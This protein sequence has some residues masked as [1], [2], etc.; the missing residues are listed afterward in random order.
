MSRTEL[1]ILISVLAIVR[2]SLAYD[3]YAQSV[4]AGEEDPCADAKCT[5]G[6]YCKDGKCH[7]YDTCPTDWLV[8]QNKI[9]VDGY[10][11]SHTC[12]LYRNIC[13]CR[14][15]DQRCGDERYFGGHHAD[16]NSIIR[17]FAE[18]Q[19]LTH[20]CNWA[21]HQRFFR[22]QLIVWLQQ[23]LGS[24]N[25]GTDPRNVLLRPRAQHDW[26]A[27]DNLLSK[28]IGLRGENAGP[29]L[30]FV[31]CEL[32]VDK[33]GIIEERELAMLTQVALPTL[34][35]LEIFLG[36]CISGRTISRDAWFNCFEIDTREAMSCSNFV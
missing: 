15:G 19:E 17:Y 18:C 16:Q 12:D 7:C 2:L 30:S 31:F 33:S 35:C 24:T 27:L 14:E 23:L 36:N 13:Y 9:C 29:I 1:L 25:H 5:V 20:K 28:R 11:Y 34:A 22:Y 32:D 26:L 6:E 21:V 4:N 10:T 3:E 8:H